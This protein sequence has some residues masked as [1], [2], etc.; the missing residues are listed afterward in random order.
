MPILG[1]MASAMSANLWQPAGAYDSL[2]TI[3][4]STSTA[5]I[6]FT[7]IPS[8]YKHLQIRGI[9]RNTGTASSG[10]GIQLNGDTAANYSWHRLYG[11]GSS[12]TSYGEPNSTIFGQINITQSNQTASAFGAFVVDILDYANSTTNKTGRILHGRDLNGSGTIA[13]ASSNWRNTNAITSITMF[14][15]ADSLAQYSSFALYGVK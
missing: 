13:L 1:I 9:A 11:D 8:T 7:G 15:A 2:A 10:L 14:P 3:T 4:L 5:S 12:A 6:T